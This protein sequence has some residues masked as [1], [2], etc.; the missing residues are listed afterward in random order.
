LAVD[1][2]SVP[3]YSVSVRLSEFSGPF[4]VVLGWLLAMITRHFDDVWFGAKL[5]LECK[6]VP[7]CVDYN[8]DWHNVTPPYEL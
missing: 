8:G 6:R 2:F 5:G 7:V 1:P 3:G 4:G